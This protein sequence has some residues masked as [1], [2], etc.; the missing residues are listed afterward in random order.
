MKERHRPQVLARATQS[1]FEFALFLPAGDRIANGLLDEFEGKSRGC[2]VKTALK[3][4]VHHSVG[5]VNVHVKRTVIAGVA[6][7]L[8]AF[9]FP[10]SAN[11]ELV[12]S[13][14]LNPLDGVWDRLFPV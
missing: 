14:S 2:I 13:G 6:S 4:E 9:A 8:L 12:V 10:K 5:E 3:G 11:F 7:R 1:P